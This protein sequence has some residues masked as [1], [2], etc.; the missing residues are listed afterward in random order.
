MSFCSEVKSEITGTKLERQCCKLAL[1]N[2]AF[3]FFTT[4]SDSKIKMNTE[5]KDVAL[6]LNLLLNEIPGL[7]DSSRFKQN[8]N[9]KGYVFEL[10]KKE[11]IL[12]LSEEIG[13]VN[14][15]INQVAG[16]IDD[17]KSINPCCQRAAV[18]GAFLVAGSVTNP[19]RGYHFEISNHRQDNL[20]KINEIL[21]SMDFYPKIIK[22]G[23]D[24]VLYIK[25]KEA[26]ADMLNYLGCKETFFEFHDTIILKDK[27]NQ[28]NR[29]MNCENANMDKTVN[30]AVDQLMSIRALIDNKVFET[31]SDNLK[32]IALLR[33]N[34]PDASLNELAR[35]CSEPITR[36]GVNHRLKKIIEIGKN[37][38]G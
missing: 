35:M 29:M 5:S 31:L 17:N 14:K 33:L 21:V 20:H 37:H 9:Q 6:F 38:K 18:V 2:S 26:I 30:A 11:E 15:K 1:L 4:V 8:K 24:Y 34:N 25:E 16:I 19:G 28:L 36:S 22:R 3:A 13:L 23:S 27:K 12:K 32:E 7:S 10:N